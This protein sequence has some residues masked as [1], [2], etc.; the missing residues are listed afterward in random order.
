MTDKHILTFGKYKHH[1]LCNVPSSYLLDFYKNCAP[2]QRKQYN[3]LLKYIEDNMDKI[4]SKL[5]DKIK[6]E[7]VKVNIDGIGCKITG[8]RVHLICEW[9]NK[10]IFPSENDAKFEIRRIRNLEQE[11]KK[12]KRTYECTKCGG[13]HL[14]SKAKG[15]KKI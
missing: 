14:T 13:W 15:L 10:I 6:N 9:T 12:P 11:N 5:G 2:S 7:K 1:Q 8:H 4:K 3:V